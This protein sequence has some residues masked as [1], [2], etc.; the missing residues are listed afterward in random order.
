MNDEDE[1]TKNI[2]CTLLKKRFTN[3][4]QKILYSKVKVSSKPML[5]WKFVDGAHEL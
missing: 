3:F 5:H 2:D 4:I 1:H